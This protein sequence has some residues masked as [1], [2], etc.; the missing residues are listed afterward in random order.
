MVVNQKLNP[1]GLVGNDRRQSRKI[2]GKNECYLLLSYVRLSCIEKS[3][4]RMIVMRYVHVV[5][6][7]VLIIYMYLKI[8]FIFS[9]VFFFAFIS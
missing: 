9:F 6:N 8:F 1:S 2:K 7:T 4:E 3:T 5:D